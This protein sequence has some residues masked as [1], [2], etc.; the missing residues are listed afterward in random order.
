MQ[1]M[2]PLTD[3]EKK[4]H[5]KQKNFYICKKDLVLMTMKNILK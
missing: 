4:I 3:E 5:H 2:I 1:Q